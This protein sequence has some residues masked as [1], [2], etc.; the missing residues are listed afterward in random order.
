MFAAALHGSRGLLHFLITPCKSPKNC[1]HY[2]PPPPPPALDEAGSMAYPGHL[3]A[4]L[5]RADP[6][7]ES[8]PPLLL[9]INVS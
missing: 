2:A 3:G 7:C 1:G 8:R 5:G 6:G 4:A 9:R